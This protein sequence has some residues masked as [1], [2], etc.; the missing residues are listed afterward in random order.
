MMCKLLMLLYFFYLMCL[1]RV[2]RNEGSKVMQLLKNCG[3]VCWGHFS[4]PYG[5]KITILQGEM[6]Y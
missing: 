6:L 1:L 3:F 2:Q 5:A 4:F